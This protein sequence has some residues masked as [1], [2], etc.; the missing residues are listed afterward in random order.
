MAKKEDVKTFTKRQ[1]ITSKRYGHY[2]FLRVALE[3]GKTYSH[4][5]IESI[6]KKFTKEVKR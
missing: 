3:D 2:Y 4:A 1:I 5:D 6:L